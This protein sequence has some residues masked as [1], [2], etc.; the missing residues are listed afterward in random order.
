MKYVF[1]DREQ[2]EKKTRR[3]CLKKQDNPRIGRGRRE[4]FYCLSASA[5][6]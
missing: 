6:R 4:I 1:G 5:R 3:L 2:P